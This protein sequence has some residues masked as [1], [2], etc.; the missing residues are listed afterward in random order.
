MEDIPLEL[1]R[2][3]LL[4]I[5]DQYKVNNKTETKIEDKKEEVHYGQ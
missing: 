3:K 5:K 1:K 4:E 2:D